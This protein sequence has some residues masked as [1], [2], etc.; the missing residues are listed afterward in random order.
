LNRK[1]NDFPINPEILVTPSM[2]YLTKDILGVSQDM[3]PYEK[4]FTKKSSQPGKPPANGVFRGLF[5]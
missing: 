5:A 2:H 1:K 3:F 4:H